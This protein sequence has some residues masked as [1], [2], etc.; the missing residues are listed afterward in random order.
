[1]SQIL[2]KQFT[3]EEIEMDY[4]LVKKILFFWSNLFM[5]E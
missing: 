2:S 1:M 5:I 3:K 4:K